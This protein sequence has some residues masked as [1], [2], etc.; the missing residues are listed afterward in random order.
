MLQRHQQVADGVHEDGADEGAVRDECISAVAKAG[1]LGEQGAID[2]VAEAETVDSTLESSLG[3]VRPPLPQLGHH[4]VPV[5]GR[6]VGQNHQVA[7]AAAA[8]APLG[9]AEVTGV[10]TAELSAH[11]RQLVEPETDALPQAGAVAVRESPQHVLRLPLALLGHEGQR[12]AKA[13]NLAKLH[14]GEPV[15]WAER[16]EDGPHRVLRDVQIGQA[17]ALRHAS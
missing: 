15:F 6:A 12:E 17:N 9:S 5:V 10:R 1:D 14:Q 4:A 3:V 8:A 2:L 13:G 11:R 16:L 7:D